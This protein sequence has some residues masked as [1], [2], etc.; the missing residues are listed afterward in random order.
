MMAVAGGSLEQDNTNAAGDYQKY[1][2]QYAGGQGGDYHKYMEQY[3]AQYSTYFGGNKS[4]T[5][6]SSQGAAYE[7]YMK[8]QLLFFSQY[9]WAYLSPLRGGSEPQK[10]LA[11]W[12]GRGRMKSC[13]TSVFASLC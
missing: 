5:P 6:G 12:L 1:M 7:N 4:D 2:S 9:H 3:A 10:R 11:T 13:L 8:K